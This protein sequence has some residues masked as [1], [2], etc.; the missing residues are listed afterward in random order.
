MAKRIFLV[1]TDSFGIGE[2][3]D[4]K[5][6]GDFGSNT[7]AAVCDASDKEGRGGF[8][9]LARL[10]LF[11]ID[12]HSD[13]RISNHIKL[14]PEYEA[15]I[16]TYG[17]L[18]ELS[19]GKDTTIGHWE[20]AGV[21]SA[22][23]LPT[24]PEGFPDKV[25]NR[26]TEIS[27][28]GILVNKPYSGTAVINEYGDEHVR[29]GKLIV[30]TSADSVLQI[31]AHEDVVPVEELYRI[32]SEM[33]VFMTG[34]YA[35]GRI[36]ARPFIGKDGDYERTSRRHDFSLEPTGSTMLD[37][38]KGKG[39]EV[40]AVGKITDIFAGRGVT[41]TIRT[42]GNT[43]G[44]SVLEGLLDRDFN[45]LCFVNLVDFDMK[46]GHRND[47]SGYSN[48]MHEWDDA[49]GRILSKLRPE[50]LF[51]MT[52]DHGCDPST[53]STDHSRECVPVLA[54]GDGHRV[55]FNA[56]SQAGFTHVSDMVMNGL[57]G[58]EF[59]HN[60]VPEA[61][62][63]TPSLDNPYSYVDLTNLKVNAVDTDIDGLVDRAIDLGCAS[64]CIQACYVRR[65]VKRA[66]GRLAIC[67][68][69]GFPNGYSTTASKVFEASEAC[70]NGASEVDMVV[71]VSF[72]K[73]G[74]FDL[75]Q[76]EI[77]AIA[78][79]VHRRGAIL[80]V[81]IETCLLTDEEKIRLCGIVS[82]CGADFIKTSTG[83][84]TA[85]ANAH[86]VKLMRENVSSSVKVKAAGGIRTKEALAEM[87]EAGASR[88]GA[89]NIG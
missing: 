51:I 13:E 60:Y 42:L 79:A 7:L 65:A 25:L 36:I 1:V 5:S 32:C 49:I 85:G 24:F 17:R 74:R 59:K 55:P 45:G 10:G 56:G 80:K 86:D 66:A 63:Q 67:T 77:S 8:L 78:E 23:P 64:V 12:G 39:L 37:I 29:T 88:I 57:F 72:V 18:R 30:Y 11:D 27:G 69:I 89:S 34:K 41:E 84:S 28:R 44:I 31:A 9:N 21:M 73:S 47:A 48:A 6:F 58:R 16:G 19:M 50:D 33:R 46:Y 53:A 82:D 83:F 14:H 52:S 71:N 35:V 87:V 75:V 20:M 81:I 22:S 38:I 4:A 76:D 15:P 26:L 3:P 68:V 70:D 61:G 54:Y 43:E 40:I 62:I 2:A